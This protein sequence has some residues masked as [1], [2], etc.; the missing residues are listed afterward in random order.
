MT[1][2]FF[3]LASAEGAGLL[4]LPSGV[5]ATHKRLQHVL[6]RP[7]SY[8]V[9]STKRRT[10]LYRGVSSNLTQSTAHYTR[11]IQSTITPLAPRWSVSQ[12]P[13]ALH[14]YQVPPPRRT[15]HRS[16]Q[17]PYYNKA[18]KMVQHIADHANPA[19]QLL[20]SADR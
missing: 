14:R 1:G 16:A 17:T 3:C 8:T 10:W 15:L 7:C 6:F 18:Y 9:H 19:G 12:R 5:S 4:F 20:P 2:L 13:D 11:P